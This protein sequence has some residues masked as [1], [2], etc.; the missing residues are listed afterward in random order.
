MIS[1]YCLVSVRGVSCVWFYSD[2]VRF[3]NVGYSVFFWI[4]HVMYNACGHCVQWAR[5]HYQTL[6]WGN[7]LARIV[8]ECTSRFRPTT[9]PDVSSW[10]ALFPLYTTVYSYNL[11][12]NENRT[13][14]VA[15]AGRVFFHSRM[16]LFS[17]RSPS[18]PL[19]RNSLPSCPIY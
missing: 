12:D 19:T 14:W 4:L 15:R 8:H 3:V 16:V 17:R 10:A 5:G 9:S 7:K 2:S 6:T 11:I 18:I 13:I 1:L